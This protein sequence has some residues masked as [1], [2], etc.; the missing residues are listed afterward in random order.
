[1]APPVRATGTFTDATL[2]NDETVVAGG[3]TYTMKTSLSNT[4]GF[5]ALGA[6]NT[7]AL[8][9]L[10]AAINLEA[11]AG[12]KYA[13]ATTLND[14]V[15]ATASGATTLVVEAKVPGTVGNFIPTTET[16]SSG[17]WGATTLASGT[18]NLADYLTDMVATSQLNADVISDLTPVIL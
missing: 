6:S 17:S 15:R 9:N 13:A 3:K 5:V 7:A 4:D 18:G 12:T 2:A 14:H 8:A 11:G 10:K 16:A 1:M